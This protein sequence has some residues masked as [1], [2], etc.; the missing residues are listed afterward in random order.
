[1][2]RLNP[3]IK[4]DESV[5]RGLFAKDTDVLSKLKCVIFKEILKTD[6]TTLDGQNEVAK[7]FGV[8]RKWTQ[9]NDEWYEKQEEPTGYRRYYVS[10]NQKVQRTTY[11]L[12][13]LKECIVMQL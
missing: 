12:V 1:M 6:A 4:N 9:L 8:D 3:V 10:S 2:I 7:Y 13:S 5:K 11:G